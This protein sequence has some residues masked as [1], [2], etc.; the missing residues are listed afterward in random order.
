MYEIKLWEVLKGGLQRF[1]GN[2]LKIFG[3]VFVKVSFFNLNVFMFYWINEFIELG[4]WFFWL[5]CL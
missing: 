1:L 2:L 3:Y 4:C 5:D